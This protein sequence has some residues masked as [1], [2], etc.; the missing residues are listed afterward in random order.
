MFLLTKIV[1]SINCIA[2][3]KGSTGIH[4]HLELPW[5]SLSDPQ[6]NKEKTAC[7]SW[8]ELSKAPGI[9]DFIWDFEIVN[10]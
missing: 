7:Q 1:I 9:L 3:S 10:F 4:S 5:E 2:H 6:K 8:T